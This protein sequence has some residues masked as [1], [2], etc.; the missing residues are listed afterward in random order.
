MEDAR[1]TPRVLVV[2][3]EKINRLVVTRMIQRVELPDESGSIAGPPE[4]IAVGSGEAALEA[5]R[6]DHIDLVLMD[7]ELPG[8]NGMDT[9]REI[10][11]GGAG[12]AMSAVPVIAM[13][14]HDSDEDR[15]AC[16]ESGMD[17]YLTKPLGLH[18]LAAAVSRHITRASLGHGN[19]PRESDRG[20][21][22]DED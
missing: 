4:T 9:T 6:S 14:G 12:D 15:S 21:S 7:I 1:R 2:E 16:M 18:A 13:S 19:Q 3:D 8:K 22:T 11:S 5:L 10:R 20:R 17:D